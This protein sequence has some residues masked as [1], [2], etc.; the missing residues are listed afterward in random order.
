[1]IRFYNKIAKQDFLKKSNAI[2]SNLKEKK[3][4]MYLNKL[5]NNKINSIIISQATLKH[6]KKYK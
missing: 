2:K 1:M 4:K 5:L 6:Y 3:I